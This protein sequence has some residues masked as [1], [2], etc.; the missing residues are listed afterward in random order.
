[1]VAPP[2]RRAPHKA[3]HYRTRDKGVF[4]NGTKS[5]GPEGD[6][7]TELNEKDS[8][9][10]NT[11]KH[12]QQLLNIFRNTYYELLTS[13][14][15]TE[16]LQAV[17]QALFDRDF[18]KA[19]GDPENLEIYAARW[20]PTRA[21]CYA[22]VFAGIRDQLEAITTPLPPTNGSE[23]DDEK[24]THHL[25]LLSIGGCAAELIA[26]ASLL[27]SSPS[28]TTGSITLLDSGPW[29]SVISSLTKTITTPPPIS[30]YASAAVK[31]RGPE[32]PL[33]NPPSRL[34]SSNF[35]QQ[36][37]LTLG[38][39]GLSKTIG[40]NPSLITLLFTLNELFTA[41]GIGKTTKFLLDLTSV[42]PFGSLL[43]VV[44]SPGSYSE[45]TLGKES[46]RYPM[47]WL[48]DRIILGTQKE[49]VA[50]RRWKKLE[51]HDSVWFRLDQKEL[52]Y[53]IPLENMRYQMHLYKVQD[54]GLPDNSDDD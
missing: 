38:P 13:S 37:V 4:R 8:S 27:S 14:N 40:P 44:D 28:S 24:H 39:D 33:I 23:T 30:K 21:L 29:S 50:G 47:Q 25:S 52:D 42:V 22:S 49:P 34:L 10:S 36:D 48:L 20:S 17:K 31:S 32:P 54:A 11:L 3:I 15:F 9:N 43:L 35:L 2:K 26:F 7:T 51:S 18:A 16:K 5:G 19:F 53:P 46:K 1:M 41:S 6:V 12:N 45:T